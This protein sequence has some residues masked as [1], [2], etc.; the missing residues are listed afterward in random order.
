MTESTQG[1]YRERMLRALLYI[2]KRLDEPI[3]LEELAG[4][5]HFSPFHFHRVFRGMVGESVKSHIRRLRLE[6]AASMLALSDRPVTDIALDAGYEAHAAFTRAFRTVFGESPSAYRK[7]ARERYAAGMREIAPRPSEALLDRD[8]GVEDMDVSIEELP[9]TKVVF[10]RHVGPYAECG[11]A[12]EK[13]C[14]WAGPKGIFGPDTR[15]VGVCHDDPEVT[16]PEKIRYD[17][18]LT[19]TRDVAP[20]GD[21]GVQEIGGGEYAVTVH[22]GPYENLPDAYAK[23]FG[24]WGPQSGREFASAPSL[25]FYLNDPEKTP[26]AERLT[27]ICA[28]LEPR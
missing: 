12:W 28:K 9:K 27:K 2:E 23:L 17:A 18:A 25:E 1:S 6:R 22:Q 20:E 4:V 13:V 8:K 26:P 7:T 19:V 24:V 3:S 11:K 21:I 16:P 14:A 15:T 10:A 5:A